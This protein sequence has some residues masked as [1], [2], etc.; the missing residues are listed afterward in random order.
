MLR[1]FL[2]AACVVG[3]TVTVYCVEYLVGGLMGLRGILWGSMGS[4]LVLK[5]AAVLP[6]LEILSSVVA[7]Q[8]W[9]WELPPGGQ[10]PR[11]L[12]RPV[13]PPYIAPS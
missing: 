8:C 11:K 3:A 4:K 9:L 12:F 6:S 13:F 10:L 2:P 5:A 1:W 7:V